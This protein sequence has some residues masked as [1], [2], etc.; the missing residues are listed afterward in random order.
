MRH[1]TVS[2]AYSMNHASDRTNLFD[3]F[4]LDFAQ[5]LPDFCRIFAGFSKL[6]P[7]EMYRV[8]GGYREGTGRLPGRVPAVCIF[9]EIAPYRASKS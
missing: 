1:F 6:G 4:S 2:K 9:A 8:P 5:I 7:G 3:K